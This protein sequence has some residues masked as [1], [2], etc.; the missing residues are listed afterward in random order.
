MTDVPNELAPRKAAM[1]SAS[2]TLRSHHIDLLRQ[3]ILIRRF[4][5][6]C[7]ELYTQQNLVASC[8]YTSVRKRWV[9]A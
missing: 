4:E 1:T 5:E 7:A 8:I 2:S 6:K 9:W 3:M